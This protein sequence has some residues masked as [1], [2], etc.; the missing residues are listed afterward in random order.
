MDGEMMHDQWRVM[1]EKL[2][3][4]LALSRDADYQLDVIEALLEMVYYEG[5]SSRD[6]SYGGRNEEQA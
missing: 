1:A 2:R 6:A 4:A 3:A 5:A